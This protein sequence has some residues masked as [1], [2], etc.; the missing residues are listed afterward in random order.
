MSRIV[1]LCSILFAITAIAYG[2]SCARIVEYNR[3]R[4]EAGQ[5]QAD[6]NAL[7]VDTPTFEFYDCLC[8]TQKDDLK[9][10]EICNDSPEIQAQYQSQVSGTSANCKAVEDLKAAGFG[11]SSTVPSVFK[12][13]TLPPRPTG[14]PRPRNIT[15]ANANGGFNKSSTNFADSGTGSLSPTP[16]LSGVF[17]ILISLMIA[18]G[19]LGVRDLG[20]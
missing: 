19:I 1:L 15:N 2:N 17:S 20:A 7:V 10:Y 8:K 11:P 16:I 3:C 18:G 5:K 14:T 9:C 13:R 6:C 12:S 4:N